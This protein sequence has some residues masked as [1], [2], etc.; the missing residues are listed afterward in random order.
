MVD[1]DTQATQSANVGTAR[2]G[3]VLLIQFAK[4]PLPRTVKT[5]MLPI[6]S[7]EQACDLHQELL[8]WTCRT[9]CES[10]VGD[11]ELWVSGDLEHPAFDRCRQYGVS[12]LRAQMGGDLG[13]RMFNAM[14]CLPLSSRIKA[15]SARLES[16]RRYHE[17]LE[18]N[19][20]PNSCKA[21]SV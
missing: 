11:V 19:S 18:A 17:K 3:G 15:S 6:L 1:T 7:A 8:L 13:E 20:G 10:A 14:A 5:R 12:A 9:L 2:P 16:V 4:S 21:A